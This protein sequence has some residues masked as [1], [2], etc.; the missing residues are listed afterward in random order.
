MR[1]SFI[2]AMLAMWSAVCA[3]PLV[4]INNVNPLTSDVG[5][6][7]VIYP[8]DGNL[9][10]VN[11]IDALKTIVVFAAGANNVQAQI[12]ASATPYKFVGVRVWYRIAKGTGIVPVYWGT[13]DHVQ[14]AKAV[15]AGTPLDCTYTAPALTA[16][17]LTCALVVVAPPPP[18]P[19]PVACVRIPPVT[20]V[21]GEVTDFT[22]KMTDSSGPDRT[23]AP[24]VEP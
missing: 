4:S 10:P 3:E 11:Q 9:S 8:L 15:P 18:P 22:A 24:R 13:F 21:T 12:P 20:P 2:A 14:A 5:Y 17:D 23:I 19:P 6:N 7:V 16:G 1:F